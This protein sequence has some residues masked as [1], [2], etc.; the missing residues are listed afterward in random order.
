MLHAGSVVWKASSVAQDRVLAREHLL[1][2]LVVVPERCQRRLH[3]QVQWAP[4]SRRLIRV[5]NYTWLVYGLSMRKDFLLGLPHLAA[6]HK[7][8]ANLSSEQQLG[9]A[10]VLDSSS[11]PC[12]LGRPVAE[13]DCVGCVSA[14]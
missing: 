13:K 9:V 5:L 6:V 7:Q 1:L 8:L 3:H 2:L 11:V 14:V 12:R 10:V 4:C